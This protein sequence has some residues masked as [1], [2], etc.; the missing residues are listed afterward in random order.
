MKELEALQFMA[1]VRAIFDDEV[2]HS[3][4]FCTETVRDNDRVSRMIRVT[5]RAMGV[6]QQCWSFRSLF[7]FLNEQSDDW[8][9]I[10]NR[11]HGSQ[12]LKLYSTDQNG[13]GDRRVTVKVNK[14]WNI[15]VQISRPDAVVWDR[16]ERITRQED[17]SYGTRPRENKQARMRSLTYWIMLVANVRG[18]NSW[19]N[20]PAFGVVD[21]QEFH[22][23]I[24]CPV[25]P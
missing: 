5:P 25:S 4:A 16:R 9:R 23:I 10:R 3:D 7:T 12:R 17:T 11:I 21:A 14:E 1:G 20:H 22:P 19:I 6:E 8:G 2:I 13:K 15:S 18:G 24:G